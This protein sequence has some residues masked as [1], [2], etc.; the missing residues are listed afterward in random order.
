MNEVQNRAGCCDTRF[1]VSIYVKK[2]KKLLQFDK[3]RKY[4]GYYRTE[5]IL[6]NQQ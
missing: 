2:K 1:V 6:R 4:E 5:L 3:G